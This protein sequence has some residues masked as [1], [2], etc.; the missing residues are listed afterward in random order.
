VSTKI[1][2]PILNIPKVG[3]QAKTKRHGAVRKTQGQTT[4]K[5]LR[6]IECILEEDMAM[7][8]EETFIPAI[9]IGEDDD[10]N[11]DG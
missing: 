10:D 11:D 7:Q 8:E 6:H 3:H 5:L 2:K 1:E 4:Q 9:V